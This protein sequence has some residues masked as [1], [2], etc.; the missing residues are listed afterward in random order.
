LILVVVLRAGQAVVS[1]ESDP[2]RPNHY[3]EHGESSDI[4]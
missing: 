4:T 1:G 2:E 3:Q